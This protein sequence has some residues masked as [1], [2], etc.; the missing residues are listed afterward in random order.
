MK[1]IAAIATAIGVAGI[2]TVAVAAPA[3]AEPWDGSGVEFGL[4]YWDYESYDVSI[5]DVDLITGPDSEEYTDIWD[6]MGY[7]YID[8][9]SL[10]L[11]FESVYC[12]PE[13]TVDVS[14]DAATGDLLFVCASSNEDF[15]DAG[16]V[17][18]SEVR[19]YAASDLVRVTTFLYNDTDAEV[20]ID[21]VEFYT[22]F[23]SSGQLWGYQGQDDSILP[24]P[25]AEDTT[26]SDA[27]AA[28]GARWAVHYN[29]YDAPGGVAWGS[30]DAAAPATLNYIDGDE[31]DASVSSFTIP[32]GDVRAVSYFALWNPALLIE[33]GYTN[34]ESGVQEQAADALVPAMA[35]FDTFSGRLTA[36]L[37][38]VSVVNWGQVQPNPAPVPV[39]QPEAPK[40]AATG[41]EGAM[42]IAGIAGVL[43]LLGAGAVAVG[44]RRRTAAN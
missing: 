44:I 28:A 43:V 35:E 18:V 15:A 26:S 13:D 39:P 5:N 2:M 29:N 36:G 37:E 25:A 16:L 33:L 31:Y 40:L 17:V 38:G 7:T 3:N 9:A 6:G 22:D 11:D 23:G 4:G 34:E 32:A 8:S 42:G 1:S 21:E 14:T 20:T 30:S 12:D 27:L 19:I 10:G 41:S 24:V